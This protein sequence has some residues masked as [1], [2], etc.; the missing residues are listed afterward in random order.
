M[1]GLQKNLLKNTEDGCVELMLE[2]KTNPSTHLKKR[3]SRC[4]RSTL[5][6]KAS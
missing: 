5:D 2:M 1:S 3:L 4:Q 6:L